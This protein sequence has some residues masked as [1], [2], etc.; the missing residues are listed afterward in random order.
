[1]TVLSED[2]FYNLSS[3]HTLD[4]SYNNL[5]GVPTRLFTLSKSWQILDFRRN[6]ISAAPDGLKFATVEGWVYVKRMLPWVSI[7]SGGKLIPS[8]PCKQV[9]RAEYL[10]RGHERGICQRVQD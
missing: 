3:I 6:N 1:V 9:V 4:L 7:D 8:V 10:G 2:S 5:T